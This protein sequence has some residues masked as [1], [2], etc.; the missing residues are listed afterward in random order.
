MKSLQ[1]CDRF[2]QINYL[3]CIIWHFTVC[4][5]RHLGHT[6]SL[7]DPDYL[8][9]EIVDNMGQKRRAPT[10]R[11]TTLCV[12]YAANS[13]TAARALA[14][15]TPRRQKPTVYAGRARKL[16]APHSLWSHNLPIVFFRIY[17]LTNFITCAKDLPCRVTK[18]KPEGKPSSEIVRWEAT[19]PQ[20]TFRP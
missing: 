2:R 8:A 16:G 17:L 1:D 5:D 11:L 3:T 19:A 18:Y 13:A 9:R 14:F 6:R 15:S 12:C 4:I 20:P 10:Q 7:P